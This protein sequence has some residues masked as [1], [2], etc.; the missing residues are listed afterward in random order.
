M[1]NFIRAGVSV[2]AVAVAAVAPAALL[3]DRGLPKTNLNNAAGGE[4]SN[5]AWG[6]V[7]GW[8][9]GDDFALSGPAPA[10]Q[11]STITTW[12]TT[13]GQDDHAFSTKILSL[14]LWLGTAEA[15]NS[16]TDTKYGYTATK[17]KYA[18]G[19]SYQGSSGSFLD[20]WQI[21]WLTSGLVLAANTK[22]N[23][24]VS[25]TTIAGST[26]IFNHA[27]NAALGGLTADGADD[28]FS[29]WDSTGGDFGTVN[30]M[31]NGWDKSSDINVMVAGEPVPEPMTLAIG[32][33]GL[34][35]AMRRR[36]SRR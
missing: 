14:N 16:V 25:G 12:L 23:F 18:D 19:T 27:S 5:V 22:F 3:F 24:G 15:P 29:G 28:L 17:V 1:K 2:F 33:A 6:F 30:S 32:V 13:S 10:Y 11:V 20:L 21:D 36:R 31:G 4:R 7:D 26:T 35:A 8:F 9:S 34:A